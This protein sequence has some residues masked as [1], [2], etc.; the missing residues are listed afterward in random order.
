MIHSPLADKL[1]W[2]WIGHAHVGRSEGD[3]IESSQNDVRKQD[4]E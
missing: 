3:K 4:N 2:E 1:D